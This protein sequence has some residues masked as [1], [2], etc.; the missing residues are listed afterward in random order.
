MN[1]NPG[2]FRATHTLDEERHNFEHK[3]FS[4]MH[5]YEPAPEMEFAFSAVVPALHL[6]KRFLK[7]SALH[8][9]NE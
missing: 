7:A 8:I 9:L 1:A 4:Y 6:T 2:G 5:F 3:H